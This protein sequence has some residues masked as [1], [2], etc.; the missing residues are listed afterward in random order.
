MSLK[1]RDEEELRKHGIVIDST[2]PTRAVSAGHLTDREQSVSTADSQA[3]DAPVENAE[4]QKLPVEVFPLL[5]PGEPSITQG[6]EDD[7][8]LA[9]RAVQVNR[10]INAT[11]GTLAQLYRDLGVILLLL[12]A[13]PKYGAHGRWEGWLKRWGISGKRWHKAKTLA[14]GYADRNQLEQ[15]AV[16]KAY[17]HA[18]A[19][20]RAKKA[21]KPGVPQ[22]TTG[23]IYTPA[24]D[25]TLCCSDFREL[26]V[27][28]LSAKAA[29][30]DPP[31]GQD[32][33]P[34]LPALGEFCARVLREDGVAIFFYGGQF[35]PD[36]FEAMKPYLTYQWL[37]CS[38][39]ERPGLINRCTQF[40]SKSQFAAVYG[41]SL[42]S[43][44]QPVEDVFPAGDKEKSLHPWARSLA[45]V[46]YC[47]EAFTEPSDL[48]TDPCAGSFTIAEA[49]QSLG[50]KCIACDLDPAC[51]EMAKKRFNGVHADLYDQLA[52]DAAD[53]T[54]DDAEFTETA[55]GTTGQ[56]QYPEICSD[57]GRPI[58]RKGGGKP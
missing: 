17:D 57:D 21:R 30:V 46:C 15:V 11:G 29:I 44:R 28:P 48:I 58:E 40:I 55:D 25:I 39:Y 10:V 54:T 27:P 7:E 12:Q 49:C 4:P 13:L 43:L 20:R 51:L 19:K 22:P 2:D 37:M 33:L 32:F 38:V 41:K 8:S 35:L 6:P 18:T 56:L 31:W 45:S 3:S 9:R 34:L 50:R 42:F 53:G 52:K 47:V 23:E 1:F 36:L 5:L 14:Q 24:V 16:K 26:D